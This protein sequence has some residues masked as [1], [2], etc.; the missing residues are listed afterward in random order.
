MKGCETYLGT[1]RAYVMELF[2]KTER[3][4]AGNYFLQ[5]APSYMFYWDL[6]M[7]VVYF[8]PWSYL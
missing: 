6:N 3:L 4:L 8:I 7:F 5:K 2:R 1:S